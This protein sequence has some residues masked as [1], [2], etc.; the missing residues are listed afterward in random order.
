MIRE[1][2]VI[3][4]LARRNEEVDYRFR[5]YLK[6]RLPL[7]NTELDA[8]VQEVADTVWAEID[9]T[10]CGNCCR[11]LEIVV[12]KGDILRLS[13]RLGITTHQFEEKYVQTTDGVSHFPIPCPFLGDDNHC[14]IYEDR[15]RACRDYP[16]LHQRKFRDYSLTT[17]ENCGTCPIVFNVWETLKERLPMPSVAQKSKKRGR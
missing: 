3:Q 7:S 17:V 14:Q 12:D 1:L 16:Y 6:E 13:K 15:P 8:T 10:T 11:T 4:K 2:P 5:A 9:C